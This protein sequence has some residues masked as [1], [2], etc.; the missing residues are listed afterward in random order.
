MHQYMTRAM[1]ARKPML[2]AGQEMQ[3]GDGFMATPVDSEYFIRSGWAQDAPTKPVRVEDQRGQPIGLGV[4]QV[5]ATM[6][7][8]E[9]IDPVLVI[10]ADPPV[11]TQQAAAAVESEPEQ[12]ELGAL[13][14]K[15]RGRPTNAERAARAAAGESSE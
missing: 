13:A 6:I 8:D 11:D 7:P 9:A 4:A 14:P 2:Y 12:P 3:P 5:P 1:V 15:R 10:E